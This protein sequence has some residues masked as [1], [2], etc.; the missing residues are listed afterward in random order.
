MKTKLIAN[1]LPQYHR[2]DENDKWWGEGYTDWV[3]VKNS[4]P[5]FEEHY[6]PHIPMN[7]NYYSLD[8][9][10][11]LRW[12]AKIAREYGI[13]GFGI[14]HYWFSKEK[15]LLC[16]PSEILL[17][18]KEIRINF[19]FIWDNSTWKRTW[20]HVK[21]NANDW[22]PLYD[23]DVSNHTNENNGILAELKYGREKEWKEHFDYINKFFKDERYIKIDEKPVFC[24]FNP[25]NGKEVIDRMVAYW[26]FCARNAGF[27]GIHTI[28]RFDGMTSINNSYGF[29]Y[30]PV[31]SGWAINSIGLRIKNKLREYYFPKIL[32]RP[33]IFDYDRIWS[34]IIY[35]ANKFSGSDM[36]LG[37]FVGYDD[38]PRRGL[39]G[40]VVINS[41]PEKFGCYMEK[42]IRI[43][44]LR[45]R[46]FIFV[47]AWN[48]WGE[49]A[50]LEPD[51][52]FNTA[53]L[54]ELK[55]AIERLEDIF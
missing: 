45:D 29:L 54:E 26:D 46:E 16:K 43:N 21:K 40:K 11:V 30:E 13:Y 52:R 25:G 9:P 33:I 5:L 42:L 14:Y 39:N 19:M 22:A 28:M 2:T 31:N 36:Y 1:Y 37:A 51:E 3:A 23:A 10:E 44:E 34:S 18:H 20:S 49:G 8:E 7:E 32:K 38:A 48:E 50:H 4:R 17:S 35:N 12:Q 47:T 41:S 27:K 55:K 53:Y 24:F 6:Q 15:N